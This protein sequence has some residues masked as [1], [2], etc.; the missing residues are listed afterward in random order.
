MAGEAEAADVVTARDPAGLGVETSVIEAAAREAEDA[1]G[2]IIKADAEVCFS[3]YNIQ[4]QFIGFL[5]RIGLRE[6]S[7]PTGRGE[8]VF[9]NLAKFSQAISDFEA[10]YFH[11]RPTQKYESFAGILRDGVPGNGVAVLIV[12][13]SGQSR[14]RVNL[15]RAS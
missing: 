2:R 14:E 11:S 4:R 12:E 7:V 13:L 5:E 8:V 15:E 3:V 10:I 6:E 9:Y 1:R